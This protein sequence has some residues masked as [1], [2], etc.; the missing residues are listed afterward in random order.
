MGAGWSRFL[1]SVGCITGTNAERRST[2][3]REAKLDSR[4]IMLRPLAQPPGPTGQVGDN[5][6]HR[7]RHGVGVEHIQVGSHARPQA[8]PV[9]ESPG[10]GRGAGQ[11][12]DGLFQR[13][14]LALPNPKGR[15]RCVPD[16]G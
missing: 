6:G 2:P 10:V 13:E 4:S 8:A 15:L 1:R 3:P 16:S 12:A 5:F 14:L 7:G 11:H 9:G